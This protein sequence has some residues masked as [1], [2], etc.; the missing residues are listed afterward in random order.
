MVKVRNWLCG[1]VARTQTFRRVRGSVGMSAAL[2]GAGLLLGCVEVPVNNQNP[3]PGP[4]VDGGGTDGGD[5]G[6]VNVPTW[7]WESPQPQG[8]NLTAL[9]GIPGAT[10][11]DDVLYAGGDSRTLLIGGRSGWKVQNAGVQDGHAILAIAGQPPATPSGTPQVLAVGFYDLAV[12]QSG[13]NWLDLNPF[14]GTGDGALY[15]AWA[16]PTAGEYFVV[17]TTGRMYHVLNNGNSWMREGDGVTTDSL[18]GLTG[19]GSAQALDLYAVGANGRIVHRVGGTWMVEANNMSSSQLNSVWLNPATNEVFAVGSNA[20]VLHKQGANWAAETPPVTTTLTGV[21]GSG[22]DVFAVGANG[23]LLHRTGANSWQAEGAGLTGELLTAVWGTVHNGQPTVYAVGNFGTIL[24][25]D[26]GTWQ[27]LS[28][29]VT[30]TTLNALW[31]RSPGEIYAV[32]NGGVILRRSGTAGVGTWTPVAAGVTTESL[33]AVSGYAAGLSGEA[34]VYAVGT[35]GTIVHKSGLFWTI[36]GGFLTNQDLNGV[37]AGNNSV[38]VVGLG[39]RMYHKTMNTWNI[40]LGP[41]NK[42]VTNDLF[43]VWG[44][45]TGTGEVVYVVGDNG[46]ILRRD[47]LGWTQEAATLTTDRLVALFGTNEDNLYAFSNK[48]GVYRRLGGQWQATQAGQISQGAAGIAGCVIP[49]TS[50]LLAIGGMGTVVR[51]SNGAWVSEP[52]LTQLPFGGVTATTVNDYYIV[53][54]NGLILHKY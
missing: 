27:A 15:A 2:A 14:L 26:G 50:D 52:S 44:T 30:K 24:S 31:T 51:R 7:R 5:G 19:T 16:T 35:T 23:T 39:G 13:A 42:A 10:S 3:P 29:R 41:G 21:W 53:G 11:A 25:R 40:E 47:M 43:A 33:T 45:G 22:S 9:W 17:G 36:D 32:G 12:R 37:W 48:G 38:Y 54:S 49:G 4:G 8:N 6:S 28:S 34:E 18:F 20:T 1:T 46:L